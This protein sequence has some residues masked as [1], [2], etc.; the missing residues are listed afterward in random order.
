MLVV[1]LLAALCAPI[2]FFLLKRLPPAHDS[3]AARFK[4]L[5]IGH[6]GTNHPSLAENTIDALLYALEHGAQGVEFDVLTTKDNVSVVFHDTNT[7]RRVCKLR[8]PE[9]HNDS[10]L[11][12]SVHQ[13]TYDTIVNQFCY[14]KGSKD[15]RVN[16]VEEVVVA[17]LER[18]RDAKLFIELKDFS[19]VNEAV[20]TLCSLIQRYNLFEQ[21]LVTSF[22]PF[23]L[24][25]IRMLDPRICTHLLVCNYLINVWLNGTDGDLTEKV[26]LSK[27]V[28]K[29]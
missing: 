23:A 3:S 15:A 19:K 20:N 26:C 7:M 16:T 28:P 12:K 2:A 1:A 11:D 13:L 10:L 6:R 4:G 21:V 25:K 8:N 18:H 27:Y 9:L 5:T 29:Y 22:N 24:Y 14:S 17:V